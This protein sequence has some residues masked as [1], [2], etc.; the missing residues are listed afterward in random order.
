MST[1]MTHYRV[2]E[3]AIITEIFRLI[4]EQTR[5]L[6][7]RPCESVAAQ[8]EERSH[9]IRDLLRQASHSSVGSGPESNPQYSGAVTVA[10]TA[11]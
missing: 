6:E 11:V 10:R 8:C 1:G 4:E 9:R 5:A 2:Q 3:K 7:S